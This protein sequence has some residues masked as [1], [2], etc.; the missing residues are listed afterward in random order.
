MSHVEIIVA[1]G[2]F[3]L[4]CAIAAMLPRP[5]ELDKRA[6]GGALRRRAPDANTRPTQKRPHTARARTRQ[7][8]RP[9]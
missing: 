4:G 1:C 9:P 3:S 6:W 5:V 2:L 8:R 7:N